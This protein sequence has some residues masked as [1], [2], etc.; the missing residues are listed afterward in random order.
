[1]VQGSGLV[2]VETSVCLTSGTV[3]DRATAEMAVMRLAVSKHRAPSLRQKAGASM[4]MPQSLEPTLFSH[5][6]GLGCK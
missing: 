2:A 3:M 1:M 4:Q 6:M 5:W